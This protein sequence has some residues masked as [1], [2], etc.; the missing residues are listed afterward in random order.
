MGFFQD[1]DVQKYRREWMLVELV[2]EWMDKGRVEAARSALHTV[3]AARS[4][5]VTPDVHARIA[6]ESDVAR[7]ES[8]LKAA[9]T[10]HS[11][12]DVFRAG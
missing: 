3:L 4:L 6:G 2:N 10:A 12:D 1:P 11:I 7:L 5:P 9:A 8:W